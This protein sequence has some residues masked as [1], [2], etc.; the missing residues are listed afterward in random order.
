MV[1]K[2]MTSH[3]FNFLFEILFWRILIHVLKGKVITYLKVKSKMNIIFQSHIFKDVLSM[4]TWK[5]VLTEEQKT[6]LKVHI[7]II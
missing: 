7:F 6:H 5:N 4:D 1:K 3:I 2:K